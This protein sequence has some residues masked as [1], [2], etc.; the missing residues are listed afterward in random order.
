MEKK[1]VIPRRRNQAA[2]RKKNKKHYPYDNTPGH[3]TFQ[4]TIVDMFLEVFQLVSK[5]DVYL[6]A[7]IWLIHQSK[8][9][10]GRNKVSENICNF[11]M[12]WR[13]RVGGSRVGS[14]VM[15]HQQ[16]KN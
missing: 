13:G 12:K 6:Q 15:W 10:E 4:I 3:I 14:A 9:G 7:I 5:P 2:T 8:W 16:D 11:R 1:K